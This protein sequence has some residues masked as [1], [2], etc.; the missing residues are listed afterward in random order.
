M[1]MYSVR[2]AATCKAFR[3]D[4]WFHVC[5]LFLVIALS[6]CGD[7]GSESTASKSLAPKEYSLIYVSDTEGNQEIFILD[8]STKAI[9]NLTKNK[10]S[11]ISPSWWPT[12][13]RIVFS[14]SRTGQ[15]DIYT[16]K[17]D[18]SD[19]TILI[20]GPN[21]QQSPMVSPDGKK[22]AY[23]EFVGNKPNVKV[24]DLETGAESTVCSGVNPAWS[25]DGRRISFDGPPSGGPG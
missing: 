15:G 11:D 6:G 8:L 7:S 22:L 21:T 19:Q 23:V 25:S 2:K 12:R 18:G 1:K 3:W 24:R 10:A 5:V 4:K 14:S 20:G 9:R 17:P 16:M 13:S